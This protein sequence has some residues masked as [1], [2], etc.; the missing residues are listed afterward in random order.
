MLHSYVVEV[1]PSNPKPD[2]ALEFVPTIDQMIQSNV[3]PLYLTGD[4]RTV[5][6]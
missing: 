3:V 4:K 1:R 5:N 2:F 6:F